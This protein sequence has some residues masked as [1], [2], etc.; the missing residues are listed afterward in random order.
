[1]D[2]D[3]WPNAGS[4]TAFVATADGRLLAGPCHRE[5]PSDG[6][7][8]VTSLTFAE[9]E[10]T[11]RGRE[12]ESVGVRFLGFNAEPLATTDLRIFLQVHATKRHL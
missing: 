2:G 12:G 4:M 10:L 3:L 7:L 5:S 9:A 11:Q 8:G 1:M 6:P